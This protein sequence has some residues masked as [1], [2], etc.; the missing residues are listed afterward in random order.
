MAKK[1]T[2][3]RKRA[4]AKR[5]TPPAGGAGPDARILEETLNLAEDVGWDAVRLRAVAARLGVPLAEVLDHYRDLDAVADAWFRRA[6]AAMLAP[7]PD[8]FDALPARERLYQAI[9]RWFDALVAHRRVT[10]QILR[11]KAYPS[12]PHHWVPMI[13]NLSRTVHW[14]REAAMLDATGRQRQTEEVGLTALFLATL[15]DW[16]RDE[17]P[18]QER[19]R[20]ALRRRLGLADRMMARIW[21]GG[22]R[23]VTRAAARSRAKGTPPAARSRR[24]G[25]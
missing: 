4:A 12:H 3:T 20:D 19:T 7:P 1:A 9:L 22:P 18:G 11:A 25:R 8:G 13:F 21:C 10:G 14:L 24:P 5:T 15:A 6:W 2:P 17:T 16:L 23:P